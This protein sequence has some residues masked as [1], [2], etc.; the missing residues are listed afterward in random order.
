MGCR[1][2]GGKCD[3]PVFVSGLC[4]AHYRRQQRGRPIDSP[5]KDKSEKAV[6]ITGARVP[7]HVVDMLN[8][9]AKAQGMSLYELMNSI[10]LDWYDRVAPK[11]R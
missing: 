6:A 5:I 4:H 8:T 10:V 1:G 9:V 3:R 7:Q 2:D 11:R